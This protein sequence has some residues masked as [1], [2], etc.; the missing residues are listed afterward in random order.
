MTLVVVALIGLV[1]G[2]LAGLF[3][4]GGGI[5]FVP[6]LALGL[7]LTQLHAEASSLLAVIPAA[8]VG[9]WRQTRYG[10]V[11]LRVAAVVGGAAILGVQGGVL[12]AESLP[13]TLLRR[14]FGV[15]LLLT[16]AQIVWRTRRRS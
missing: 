2:V 16:A 3:G 7:G 11:D 4:V 15:L 14:L 13:E 1:G 12:L 10:N 5:V 8:A 9:T 6:T